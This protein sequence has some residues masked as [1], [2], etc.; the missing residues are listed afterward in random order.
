M[1]LLN[2]GG[3]EHVADAVIADPEQ[4]TTMDPSGAVR[5]IQAANITMPERDLDAVWTPMHLERLART[6]WKYLSRATL[7][8]VRVEYTATE[9]AVVFLFRPFVLLRFRA[10]DYEMASD[11]GLVRWPIRNG[12][13]VA[14]PDYGHLE[15]EV[16]RC[17]ADRPGYARAHVEVEVANFSPSIGRWVGRWVYTMTQARIH[18]FVTHGFLRSLARLDFE[19]SRSGA[20][21]RTATHAAPARGRPPSGW[22]T[23]VGAWGGPR[24]RDALAALRLPALRRRRSAVAPGQRRSLSRSCADWIAAR[25]PSGCGMTSDSVVAPAARVADCPGA[26]RRP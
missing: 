26:R 18:V 7:G 24:R 14:R 22:A 11:R 25:C 4:H 3:D 9:R 12:L 5:S 10:P 1:R 2:R 19:E 13:L 20:S 17:P 21:P 23:P 8:L 15:I 16:N 6:Y